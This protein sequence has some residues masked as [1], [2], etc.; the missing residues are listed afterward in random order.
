MGRLT[1]DGLTALPSQVWGGIRLVPLA[2]D[3]P[4]ESLRL[5]RSGF[6][7]DGPNGPYSARCCYAPHGLVAEWTRDGTAVPALGTA[8]QMAARTVRKSR[9]PPTKL[10]HRTRTRFI[11]HQTSLEAFLPL[12]FNA[13]VD[14]WNLW[15]AFASKEKGAPRED[16]TAVGGHR[17]TGLADA[18]RVFEIHPDQC[19]VLVYA[20]DTLAGALVT[21]HPDDYRAMHPTLVQDKYGEL[22]ARYAHLHPH[23]PDLSGRLDAA[24]VDTVADLRAQIRAAKEAWATFHEDV[25]AAGLLDLDY[26]I[27]DAYRMQEFTLQRFRPKSLQRGEAHVGESIMDDE[28]RLAFL[29]SFRLSETQLRRGRLLEALAEQRWDPEAAGAALGISVHALGERLRTAG[30]ESVLNMAAFRRAEDR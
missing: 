28:G 21:P 22:I 1:L 13:P 23:A 7:A 24:A 15:A 20:A 29:H 12:P 30:Y 26:R 4:I 9:K 2:R 8:L 3:E 16:L 6:D 19:G 10:D 25:M 5:H 18:L 17:V 11:P 27:S 14:A